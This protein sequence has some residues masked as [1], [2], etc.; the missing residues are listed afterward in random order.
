VIG[1]V[2]IA[3]FAAAPP[4][5][6]S[7]KER[8]ATRR[9][10]RL[11]AAVLALA[12]AIPVIAVAGIWSAYYYL[13]S[14]CGVAIAAGVLVAGRPWWIAMLPALLVGFTA[15]NARRLPEF[16]TE[17]G[18]WTP[19]SHVNR[20]Y[21]RRGMTLTSAYLTDLRGARPHLPHASTLYFT[22][23][24][25]SVGFQ[26]ADGPLVRWAYRDS[27][28][29][30]YFLSGFRLEHAARGPLFFFEVRERRLQEITGRDSLLRLGYSLLLAQPAPI[31]RD[32]LRLAWGAD[33]TDEIAYLLGWA[34]LASGRAD[35]ARACLFRAGYRD[36]GG[37]VREIDLALQQVTWGDTVAATQ[38]MQGAVRVHVMDPGAHALLADLLL[39]KDDYRFGTV[40][41]FAALTLAPD[42]P[43]NWRRWGYILVD[44]QRYPAAVTALERYRTLAGPA[45]AS[46]GEVA[47]LLRRIQPVLPGGE[48][49]QKNLGKVNR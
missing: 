42:E 37:P 38:Y 13:F 44:Q 24:P 31:A 48:V 6:E 33:P 12:G 3:A 36:E 16:S 5:K 14:M 43:T 22:G 21:L 18:A 2:A 1:A 4:R 7:A 8:A 45:A 40:E 10:A 28:L 35:S 17:G 32:L 15:E 27:S 11:A 26:N 41:A 9:Q 34:E 30:S 39:S 20:H 49:A 23:L 25:V 29:R 47:D 19:H 46:D